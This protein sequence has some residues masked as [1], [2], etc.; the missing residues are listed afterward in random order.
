[1]D[2]QGNRNEA[3]TQEKHASSKSQEQGMCRCGTNKQ[4]GQAEMSI[5][6]NFKKLE[7]KG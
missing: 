7:G 4:S 3:Y 2:E 5:K 6:E 1:M